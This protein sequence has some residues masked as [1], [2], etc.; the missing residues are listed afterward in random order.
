MKAR[1]IL[2]AALVANLVALPAMAGQMMMGQVG[3]AYTLE[4][5]DIVQT[6]IGSPD[7]ETLVAAVKAAGLVETLQGDGPFTVFAPTDSAFSQ[8][9]AGTVDSLLKPENRDQLTAVLT[10][11][12]VPGRID[13]L[14]LANAIKANGGSATYETVQGERLTFR[15]EG[16]NVVVEDARGSVATVAAADLFGSNG[17]IH[18]VDGVLLPN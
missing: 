6:A 7:H 10:Y 5:K 12:V 3:Q 8:L 11:H 9:P 13:A 15:M 17:V 2:A 1:S 16:K 18:V 4:S 14:I